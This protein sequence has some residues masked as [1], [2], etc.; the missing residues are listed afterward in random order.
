MTLK[1]IAIV[2]CGFTGTSAFYQLVDQYPVKEITIF[3]STGEF[4]PGYPY[5]AD[6]CR[7]YMLNNT[8]DSLCLVPGNRRAFLNWLETKPEYADKMDPRGHLPRQVFGEFLQ[9]AFT[10]ARLSAAVKG[11]KVTLVPHEATSMAELPDGRVQIGC[12]KGHTTADAA[13]LTTGRCPDHDPYPSPLNGSG[14]LYIANHIRTDAFDRI[15]YDATV[16]VLGTSLSA[17]DVINRLFSSDTGARFVE[18]ADGQLTFVP[19]R[20]DRH[21]VLCSRSGRL[22]ALQ[23]RS[24]IRIDRQH[25]TPEAL[26]QVSGAGRVSLQ[27]IQTA[28]LDEASDHQVTLNTDA[29]LAPYEGCKTDEHVNERAGQL[30]AKAID[31]ASGTAGENFLVDLF[32]DAQIDLWDG[33]AGTVLSPDAQMHYRADIESAFLSFFAPCPISTAQKLLALHRAGRLTV[34]K[35]VRNVAFDQAEDCYRVTHAFGSDPAKVLVNTTGSVVRDVESADQPA[36]VR[37]LAATGLLRKDERGLGASVDMKTFRSNG[38]R[39]IYVANMMLWGPGF[40]TSSAFMMALVAERALKAMFATE[41]Q[42][43]S[44]QLETA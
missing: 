25:L 41:T 39:N 21:V 13:L 12:A 17:Y 26:T 18:N 10:A 3:E 7:D 14:A 40:F 33:W 23:S 43:T 8:N 9:E 31:D 37:S 36:L 27:H 35:D 28:V 42:N 24:P 19:G 22:K 38:S 2:G 4:G 1:H 16:H 6:D 20:N 11:I 34:R 44:S 29:L 5:R 30:L 32:S 15:P